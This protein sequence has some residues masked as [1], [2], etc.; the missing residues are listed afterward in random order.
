MIDRS[1][2]ETKDKGIKSKVKH[3]SFKEDCEKKEI[4]E[5]IISSKKEEGKGEFDM[6]KKLNLFEKRLKRVEERLVEVE[7]AIKEGY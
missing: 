3:V 2:K 5:V 6:L 1:L 4:S 7:I